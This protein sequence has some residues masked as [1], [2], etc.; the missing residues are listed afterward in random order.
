MPPP[1]RPNKEER[2]ERITADDFGDSLFGSGI[3]LKDEENYMHSTFSNRHHESFATQSTSFGSSTLSPNNSF[4]LLTQG[5]NSSSQGQDGPFAGTL[6]Q[7]LSQ[8]DID[9][10]ERQ[11][12]QA[13]AIALN[14]SL[15]QH[16]KNQFL[17]GNSVRRRLDKVAVNEG[18]A[19]P[20]HG[21]YV[22]TDADK[23]ETHVAVSANGKEGIV[24]VKAESMVEQGSRFEHMLSLVSLAAGDRLRTL[25]DESHGLSRARRYGDHG[26]VP[27]EFADIAVGEGKKRD[28]KVL[29]ENITGTQWDKIP[30]AASPQQNGDVDKAETPQPLNTI[31]FA[32]KINLRLREVAERDRLAEKERTK[33]REARKRQAE[34]AAKEEGGDD[35]SA[36]DT[37]ATD[38]AP[39]LTK[40]EQQKQA[41]AAASAIEAESHGTTN[42]TASMMAFGRKGARYSWMSSAQVPT[43]RFKPATGSGSTTPAAGKANVTGGAA[44]SRVGSGTGD[45]AP[46]WGDFREDSVGGRGIQS[47]DLALVLDR[48]GREKKAL[49]RVFNKLGASS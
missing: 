2:D 10:Q 26:R 48:D 20:T 6:G 31:S 36:P 8:E 42:A 30:E 21:L 23:A 38:M 37:P 44:M 46:E 3:N 16:L 5:T 12:R 27:P 18:V 45:K 34:N 15:Q 28:E 41:R 39:K 7:P 49:Q 29:P 9:A 22:R 4:N 17:N 43:N 24:A 32:G 13:A 40:K 14:E 35:T 47:R 25:I 1:P 19:L 33:K 11:R